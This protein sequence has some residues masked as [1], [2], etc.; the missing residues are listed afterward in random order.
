MR[1]WDLAY[2]WCPYRMDCTAVVTLFRS[3]APP[4]AREL[5]ICQ[6]LEQA[7]RPARAALHALPQHSSSGGSSSTTRA[8]SGQSPPGQLP[9]GAI[10]QSPAS[11]SSRRRQQGPARRAVQPAAAPAADAADTHGCAAG[12]CRCDPSQQ[13]APVYGRCGARQQVQ[14]PQP[15]GQGRHPCSAM[16]CS[17]DVSGS[18]SARRTPVAT[19]RLVGDLY[20]ESKGWGRCS[21]AGATGAPTSRKDAAQKRHQRRSSW[22]GRRGRVRPVR[23][24]GSAGPAAATMRL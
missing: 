5:L 15:L 10:N 16:Q 18:D 20:Q 9:G 8:G 4:P 24:C 14:L 22:R 13:A 19:S 17:A 6:A 1:A 12:C 3:N 7:R 23:L 2:G 11:S 21:V